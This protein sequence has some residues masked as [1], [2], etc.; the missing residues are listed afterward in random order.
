MPL[1]YNVEYKMK[2]QIG[3]KTIKF[4]PWNT[5][6]EKDYLIAVESEPNITD[7]MLFDLLIRPCLED[8]S[9]VLSNNEQKMLIIEIRKKSIGPSFP[10]RYSCTSCKQVNDLEVEFDDIVDFKPDTFGPVEVQTDAGP[11]V[12]NFAPPRTEKLRNKLNEVKGGPDNKVEYRFTE[13]II[14][15]QDITI[16]GKIE[17]TFTYEE[18][19]EFV[20]ELPSSI[21]DEVFKEFQKMK[22]SLDFKNLN[23]RCVMCNFE[24]EVQISN[25]PSFLWT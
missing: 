12:F 2:A 13:F 18:L 11:M 25:L 7:A 20:E 10:M 3:D 9:I 1:K 23:T 19:V 14:H 4:K 17:D 6:N 24:N 16:N 21:F 15:I 22:S 8:D 5:K